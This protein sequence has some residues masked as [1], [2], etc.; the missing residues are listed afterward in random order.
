MLLSGVVRNRKLALSN[1]VRV[2]L[3][4][5]QRQRL[6]STNSNGED[7]KF[8]YDNNS[9]DYDCINYFCFCCADGKQSCSWDRLYSYTLGNSMLN[10]LNLRVHKFVIQWDL[11]IHLSVFTLSLMPYFFTSSPFVVLC[12]ISVWMLYNVLFFVPAKFTEK[13][14]RRISRLKASFKRSMDGLVTPRVLPVLSFSFLLMAISLGITGAKIGGAPLCYNTCRKCLSSWDN[15]VSVEW[16]TADPYAPAP[17]PYKIQCGH[18]NGKELMGFYRMI[19]TSFLQFITT[20]LSLAG[21]LAWKV[22]EDEVEEQQQAAAWLQREDVRAFEIR[23]EL[24]DKF[25]A[26]GSNIRPDGSPTWVFFGI[27]AALTFTLLG[28][29]NWYVLSPSRT[30]TVLI[31]LN[32]LMIL[33]STFMLHLGFFGR[34]LALYKRNFMRV[35][36]LTGRLKELGEHAVDAWWNC[37]NFVLNDD[38][39]LDYDI[40]GLAV[41]FATLVT[42]ISFGYLASHLFEF[43]FVCI[44]SAPGSYCAYLCLYYATC[45]IKIFTLATSTFEEQQRHVSSLQ[46]LSTKLLQHVIAS[47]NAPLSTAIGIA[48]EAIQTEFLEDRSFVAGPRRQYSPGTNQHSQPPR[49]RPILN[50]QDP[51]HMSD[52]LNLEFDDYFL[53]DMEHDLASSSG[54]TAHGMLGSSSGNTYSSGRHKNLQASTTTTQASSG[55]KNTKQIILSSDPAIE[56]FTDYDHMYSE[57]TEQQRKVEHMRDSYFEREKDRMS[58]Y[59]DRVVGTGPPRVFAGNA[60]ASGSIP[61]VHIDIPTINIDLSSSPLV[62]FRINASGNG[63]SSAVRLLPEHEQVIR[64]Q[65]EMMDKNQSKHMSQYISSTIS[66]DSAITVASSEDKRDPHIMLNVQVTKNNGQYADATTAGQDASN[67]SS[68]GFLASRTQ[69]TSNNGWFQ[70]AFGR[71]DTIFDNPMDPSLET[72]PTGTT[73]ALTDSSSNASMTSSPNTGSANSSP[74]NSKALN[75]SVIRANIDEPLHSHANDHSINMHATGINAP[76]LS[77]GSP[78]TLALGKTAM[79]PTQKLKSHTPVNISSLT[80]SSV[81]AHESKVVG[82]AWLNPSARITTSY[83]NLQSSTSDDSYDAEGVTG[84]NATSFDARNNIMHKTL[85]PPVLSRSVSTAT[86]I[87][88]KRQTLAEMVSQI[89]K[90]DPYPCVLGMPVMPA[91]F[92]TAKF[93]I[94]ITFI[95]L[96]THAIID[97]TKLIL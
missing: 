31:I 5:Q 21:C 89:R 44:M 88:S 82:N 7:N 73:P 70:F 42:L 69:K 34:I 13:C 67:A 10:G 49:A 2:Q 72:V 9:A 84:G 19:Q 48:G 78:R 76:A 27:V 15:A 61:D 95:F 79:L 75:P 60:A 47:G 65:P 53:D 81:G 50:D 33:T 14:S 39:A 91:L 90:Y 40:G 29:H 43:G 6:L 18:I 4:S 59:P 37:R 41:S 35:E 56:V 94:F 97:C 58:S 86:N 87:E 71:I 93:Y 20:I 11:W 83:L 92:A 12:P 74:R 66:S 63:L 16:Y 38:L 68:V 3:E 22:A 25:G 24:I 80:G 52:T 54:P 30:A 62:D 96:G 45:L 8:D 51:S 36:Y 26:P 85:S 28:W 23:Q 46:E 32:M 77:I 57:L 17:D 1:V 64:V 55:P